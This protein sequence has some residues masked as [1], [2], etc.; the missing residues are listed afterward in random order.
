MVW[1]YNWACWIALYSCWEDSLTRTA[2]LQ[3]LPPPARAATGTSHE[4]VGGSL[5]EFRSHKI[6]DCERFF[7][8]VFVISLSQLASGLQGQWW[9]K[10]NPK[11][12]A[13]MARRKGSLQLHVPA[14]EF[15]LKLCPSC[16]GF[17]A[18]SWSGRLPVLTGF[19]PQL[20]LTH[21]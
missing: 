1:W 7:G 4:T 16:G 8:S 19:T 21:C 20:L 9:Y 3:L 6:H 10:L 17:T 15:E 11:M 2:H 18:P 14:L 5:R 13:G 12:R